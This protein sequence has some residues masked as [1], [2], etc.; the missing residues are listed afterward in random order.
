[1]NKFYISRLVLCETAAVSVH[2][3][4]VHRTIMNTKSVSFRLKP[5]VG[6]ICVCLAVTCHL[7]L[8]QNDWDVLHA[9][10]V[11]WWWNRQE[12]KSQHWKLTLN[13][14]NLTAAPDGDL[15][16]QPFDRESSALTTEL[17][18]PNT[19]I[20]ETEKGLKFSVYRLTWAVAQPD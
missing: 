20:M 5:H 9:T 18:P 14:K 6:C 10:A 17:S 3:F 12:N 16:L 1:M 11:T 19:A 7:H 8:W 4:S 15:N 2:T 13:N